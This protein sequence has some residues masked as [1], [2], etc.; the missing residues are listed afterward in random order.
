MSRTDGSF[1]ECPQH[2]ERGFKEADMYAGNALQGECIV[3][4]GQGIGNNVIDARNMKNPSVGVMFNKGIDGAD[5]C[6]IIRGGGFEGVPYINSILVV[7][8]NHKMQ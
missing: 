4:T 8:V 6:C 5:E 7:G 3:K 2:L 1:F